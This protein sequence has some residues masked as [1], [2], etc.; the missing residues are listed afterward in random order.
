MKKD[1]KAGIELQ[2]IALFVSTML[3]RVEVNF[4]SDDLKGQVVSHAN[5]YDGL[6]PIVVF[7]LDKLDPID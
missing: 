3:K 7:V 2:M 6:I 5:P 1:E 4:N